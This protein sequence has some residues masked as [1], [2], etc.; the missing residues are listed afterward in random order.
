[1]R[2]SMFRGDKNYKKAIEYIKKAIE[3]DQN[4]LEYRWHNI[5]VMVIRKSWRVS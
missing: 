3:L 2:N 5:E 4:N 1:M